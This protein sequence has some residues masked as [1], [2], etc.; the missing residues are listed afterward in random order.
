MVVDEKEFTIKFTFRCVTHSFLHSAFF[1]HEAR[2]QTDNSFL[3]SSEEKQ[4][5]EER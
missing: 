3:Y 2:R 4:Q 5:I 1:K